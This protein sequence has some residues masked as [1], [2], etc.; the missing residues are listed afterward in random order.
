ML[1]K[2]DNRYTLNSNENKTLKINRQT[3]IPFSPVNTERMPDTKEISCRKSRSKFKITSEGFY[4][5][6][7]SPTKN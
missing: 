4:K 7:G 6:P 1:K 5:M 3:T 2:Y